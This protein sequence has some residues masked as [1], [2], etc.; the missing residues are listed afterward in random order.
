MGGRT[1]MPV[2]NWAGISDGADCA[3]GRI[4][5]LVPAMVSVSGS[6]EQLVSGSGR[7][8]W[9]GDVGISPGLSWVGFAVF[10]ICGI[11]VWSEPVG[12][13]TAPLPGKMDVY[14]S[15]VTLA[16]D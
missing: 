3:L 10:M 11:L 5:R 1:E 8:L 6:I 4:W 2:E 9:Q 15:S 13:K 14:W 12:E 7:V 16:S